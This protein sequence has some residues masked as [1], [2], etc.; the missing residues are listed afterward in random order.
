MKNKKAN[1]KHIYE[2]CL[3]RKNLNR[4]DSER[5]YVRRDILIKGLYCTICGK[6]KEKQ[7]FLTV[8]IEG[9]TT[10]RRM[11]LDNDEIMKV[12]SGLPV[13]DGKDE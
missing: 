9:D 4:Y 7:H 5:G 11:L 2:E 12:Y 8:P 1:H 10:C 13:L 6:L 3:I